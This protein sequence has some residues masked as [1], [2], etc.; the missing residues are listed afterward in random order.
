MSPDCGG[1]SRDRHRCTPSNASRWQPGPRRPS[2]PSSARTLD[3]YEV[4]AD[5]LAAIEAA[6]ARARDA[7][8][9][10]FGLFTRFVGRVNRAE[11][12]GLAATLVVGFLLVRHGAATVGQ[13]TAAA[14]MFHRLF[15][16]IGVMM[17]N[18][19]EIQAGAAC[20]A[21]LVGVVDMRPEPT[22]PTAKSIVA[23]PASTDVECA[24]SRSAT[25]ADP[26][27]CRTSR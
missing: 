8:I 14:L 18:F 5:H 1:T 15:N 26:L 20:L 6:S 9:S 12:L 3:A 2:N 24:T 7:E 25:A 13:T 23:Q 11:F 22:A 19:D 16:P 21:R 4:H 17:Y 27:C 10:V